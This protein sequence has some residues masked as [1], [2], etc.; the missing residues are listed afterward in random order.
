MFCYDYMC[1]NSLVPQ[2]VFVIWNG[3]LAFVAALHTQNDLTNYME[4]DL[5]TIH[6][7]NP[8]ARTANENGIRYICN[9]TLTALIDSLIITIRCSWHSETVARGDRAQNSARCSSDR[10]RRAIYGRRA[11]CSCYSEMVARGDRA[12][13]ST[14]CRSDWKGRAMGF[15]ELSTVSMEL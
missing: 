12:Q 2:I 9:T 7:S 6:V 10:T 13:N 11:I 1:L 15:T 5:S 3:S 14:R 8:R 4:F